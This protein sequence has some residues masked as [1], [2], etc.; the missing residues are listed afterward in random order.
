MKRK[1]L[2]VLAL[3]M[4]ITICG[5]SKQTGETVVGT[6]SEAE[7]VYSG[8]E[9]LEQ[10]EAADVSEESITQEEAGEE[11]A[12]ET[13]SEADDVQEEEADEGEKPQPADAEVWSFLTQGALN[14]QMGQIVTEDQL[15]AFSI[16]ECYWSEEVLPED[17]TGLYYTYIEGAEGYHYLIC[18]GKITNLSYDVID[19]SS[20]LG[21]RFES[22]ITVFQF[23]DSELY[24]GKWYC[25]RKESDI[26][27]CTVEGQ[28]EAV[29]YI[30]VLVPDEIST[31]CEKIEMF[32]GFIDLKKNVWRISFEGE[33]ID[34]ENLTHRYLLEVTVSE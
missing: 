26:S 6:E 1:G 8:N 32:T 14:I 11:E 24:Y 16:E 30:V 7:E 15:V 9:A 4:I 17:T 22:T 21:N 27:Y 29:L 34:W 33:N 19:A 20:S 3:A 31:G 18:K 10:D 28:E 5:C 12:L 2:C 25:S 23:D 13:V